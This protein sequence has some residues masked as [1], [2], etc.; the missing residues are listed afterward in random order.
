MAAIIRAGDP[1]RGAVVGYPGGSGHCG[2]AFDGEGVS[3][4]NF[5]S[6]S[7][8]WA[9]TKGEGTVVVGGDVSSNENFGLARFLLS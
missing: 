8:G 1:R 6:A 9:I 2:D 5:G 7:Q 3:V 4:A